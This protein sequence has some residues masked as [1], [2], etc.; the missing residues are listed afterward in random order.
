MNYLC[1]IMEK[2]WF[3]NWF[4]TSYY[5]ILYKN[6]N[7]EEAERF[8]NNLLSTLDIPE[9]T[10]VLD[11]ACGKGRHSVTLHA[12]GLSVTGVDLSPNSIM[13]AQENSPSAI[14]FFVHDMR[15][16]I[17][18]KTFGAIFNLFTSFGYFDDLKDNLKVI[19]SVYN[20]LELGGYFVLDFMNASN[21]INNL[22]A[23]EIK[24]VDEIQFNIKRH[25]DDLHIH[26][27]I[28]FEDQGKHYQF[29]ERVQKLTL[30][31]FETLFKTVGFQIMHTFG[32]FD[33]NPFDVTQSDRLILIAK[34]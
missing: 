10:K 27:T 17:P 8:I 24:E 14:E 30:S 25:F 2:H 3:E 33:L 4:D 5:H 32:D 1:G 19:Q 6:R 12:A 29:K 20:M 23:S 11:L 21:V 18:D 13:T 9:K 34:K 31:D 22:V 15:N 7:E 16:Q 26:K 28:E